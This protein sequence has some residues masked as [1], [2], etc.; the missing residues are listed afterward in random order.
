MPREGKWRKG[1]AEGPAMPGRKTKR[2]DG[3]AVGAGRRDAGNEYR[4]SGS[5]KEEKTP[6]R[7]TESIEPTDRPGGRLS[8]LFLSCELTTD[9]EH[10]TQRPKLAK[11]EIKERLEKRKLSAIREAPG[12]GP[13]TIELHKARL[14]TPA[15]A[16]KTKKKAPHTMC[17]CHVPRPTCQH[18]HC[19]QACPGPPPMQRY[20]ARPRRS[21]LIRIAASIAI[22]TSIVH[23]SREA[24]PSSTG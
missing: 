9:A 21:F 15:P 2:G 1:E 7:Q 11:T 17:M 6:R 12:H 19:R 24:S 23:R 16:P 13:H 10:R 22:V 5:S 3:I 14:Q 8:P 4:A 18:V 20:V